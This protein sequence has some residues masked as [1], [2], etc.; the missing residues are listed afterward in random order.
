MNEPIADRGPTRRRFLQ[1][2]V[3][4]ASTLAWPAPLAALATALERTGAQEYWD[5]VRAA[6]FVPEDRI[7]LNVGTLGAQPRAVVDAVVEHTRRVAMSLP[8]ALDWDDLKARL[9]EVLRC[10]AAGLVFPRNTTEGMSFVANGIDFDAGDEILTTD[11]EHVGGLCPWQLV[12]ARRR[13]SLRVLPLPPVESGDG[14][15]VE[16][17]RSAIGPRTR[18]V[19]VSHVNFTTGLVMPVRDIAGLCRE[20]GVIC[21]I[22]G[23]HPPGLMPVDIMGIDPDFYASSPHKWL[24]A[25]QGTGFLWMREP[26]RTRLWPTLASGGWDDLTLGAHRFNH[27]GTLDESRLAGL[28]AALRFRAAVGGD[29]IE[30]RIRELRGRLIGTLTKV[31]GLHIVSPRDD[32]RGAGMVSFDIEGVDSARLQQRLAR[33]ETAAEAVSVRT[34]VIGEY[35]YGWMRLSPHIW[36]SPAEVDRAVDWIAELSPS[37]RSA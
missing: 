9:A 17:F 2:A 5:L 18:V 24:L 29:R 32:A 22:D 25:P 27:L 11:H 1:S 21:V 20:R 31:D 30:A 34:R 23:A 14:P 13:L 15:I 4:A 8:P 10:D 7:Y 28:D 37:L 12:A 36:N 3:G 26:W 16:I 35:G 19:S 33:I 6:F